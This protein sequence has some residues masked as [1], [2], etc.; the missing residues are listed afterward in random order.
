MTPQSTKSDAKE[1]SDLS[2]CRT[3]IVQAAK[4]VFV[5]EGYQASIDKIA[6]RAGLAR[7]TLYN[8]FAN[9]S[10]LFAEVIRH[11]TDILLVSLEDDGQG[12]R[13]RLERFGLVYR[14]RLL[15]SDGL[16]LYR[17]LVAESQRFPE[18][19]N[20]AYRSGPVQTASRVAQVLD[21]AV[22]RGELQLHGQNDAMFAA[23]LLLSMLVGSDRTHYLFSGAPA[24]APDHAL[25][26]QIVDTFLRAFAGHSTLHA[27]PSSTVE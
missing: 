20:A 23:R 1:L 6:A 25:V 2:D 12:L 22:K 4:E 17:I 10:E 26:S 14:S 19:V 16:G 27:T 15:N 11:A 18:V 7:Q 5:E 24:P 9:K 21:N 13:A 8:H 3:R